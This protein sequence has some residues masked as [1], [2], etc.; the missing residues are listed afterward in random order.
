MIKQM[1]S[2]GMIVLAE[3][4]GKQCRIKTDKPNV[5]VSWQVTVIR[6]DHS[7]GNQK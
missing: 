1:R 6:Y 2:I 5:E 7:A 3:V 4:K